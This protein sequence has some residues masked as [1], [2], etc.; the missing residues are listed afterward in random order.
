MVQAGTQVGKEATSEF[1]SSRFS[2]SGLGAT[3]RQTAMSVFRVY[4][5]S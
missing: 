4:K 5:L 3:G 1:E 2:C